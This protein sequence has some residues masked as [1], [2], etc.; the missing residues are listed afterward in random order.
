MAITDP[1]CSLESSLLVRVLTQTLKIT[2]IVV[3]TLLVIAGS[4]SFFN[5][6]TDREASSDIG[7]PARPPKGR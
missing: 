4:V 1:D 3:L 2:S 6:W 7:R 5:Y